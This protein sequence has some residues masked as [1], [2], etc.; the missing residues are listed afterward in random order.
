MTRR[1]RIAELAPPLLNLL[2]SPVL[3]IVCGSYGV[4]CHRAQ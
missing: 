2:R 3:G 1:G 4:I